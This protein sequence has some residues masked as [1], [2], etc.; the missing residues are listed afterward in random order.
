MIPPVYTRQHGQTV[1][2]RIGFLVHL[3]VHTDADIASKRTH[4]GSPIAGCV[5][6]DT[7][8][9]ATKR[10]RYLQESTVF[11]CTL[12]ILSKRAKGK[13]LI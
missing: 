7:R 4:A 9:R 11:V 13:Y 8:V 1:P 10:R 2:G 5:Y 12:V 3:P 6:P